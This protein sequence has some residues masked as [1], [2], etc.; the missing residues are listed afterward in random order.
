MSEYYAYL[1]LREGGLPYYAGKGKGN[2]AFTSSG[3]IVKPPPKDRIVIYP[4]TSEEDAFETE[5]AL[6]WYYGRKNTGTGCLRNLSDGGEGPSGHTKSEAVRQRLREF[7]T[8]LKHTEEAKR[9]IGQST[10]GRIDTPETRAKKSASLI[11]DYKAG[12]RPSRKGSANGR[13]K[14]N[15]MTAEE[16]RRL[17]RDEGI[18]QRKL[19]K[20]FGLGKTTVGMLLRHQT[21][22]LEAR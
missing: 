19:G 22:K 5:I 13:A 11:R 2:R 21:W 4:A 14:I 1:W 8:G 7:H 20:M 6:I 15:A 12:K 3:H 16:I 10:L 18:P 17:H 9:K